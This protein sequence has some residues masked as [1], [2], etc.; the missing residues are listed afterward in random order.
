MAWRKLYPK[1][2][3]GIP[4]NEESANR[5]TGDIPD[6]VPVI[7][8]SGEFSNSVFSITTQ[9]LGT[10]IAQLLFPAIRK[11]LIILDDPREIEDII[12]RRNKEFDK[13]PMA[14]DIFSPMFPHA[15]ISQYTTPKLKAQKRLWAD[16]MNTEFLRRA[17]APN[18]HKATLEL[19]E[20]WKLKASTIYKD[21]SFSTLEDFRNAALDAIWVALIGEEPG[22]TRFEI[23]KL[24]RQIAGNG[25]IQNK[26]PAGV[27]L[28]EEVAYIGQ[29]IARNSNTPVPK[30][31][32]KLETYT[33]RYRKFRSTVTREISLAMEK[34]VHRFE[35]L[36]IGKL[37]ADEYD[38]CMMD[39]VLRRQVLE[40]KKE[41]QVLT[42]PTKD[43]NML[44][45]MF[46]MLV[47]GH[48]STANALT[49]FVRFMEAYPAVQ[50]E[51]RV[52][53]N[54]AFPGSEPPS[55]EDILTTDIPYLDATCEEG[56]RLAGV[57][58]GNLR[59]AIVDT[60]ILGCKIPKGAEIFMN[61]H[62]NRTP[63]PVD[64]SKRTVGS[65]ATAAKH[66]NGL[67]GDAGRDI[68]TF[69]PR[70][71]LVKDEKTGE[72][73]L[74]AYALPNIS[75]G[76]GYRGCFGRK[77]A[78]MEFRIVITLLILNLKFLELPGDFKNMR[79]SEKIFR[80][81]DKPYARL[82]EL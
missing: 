70:R 11:P 62:I 81:P 65:R 82:R 77:L 37:E 75:F 60:E 67:Q 36:E 5:V 45:E 22:I 46:V 7:E 64:E 10:P 76:G 63:V 23:I 16:V 55:V 33:P 12:V 80:Q 9:K 19:I 6:L 61:Y 3:L 71:W 42:D 24:Q 25:D 39:L 79:A 1:P 26:P 14:I 15:S 72:E 40:A 66:G 2:Y 73:V 59:Q 58:K 56:F 53:L 47:G 30:W 51:L 69:E 31:A 50:T 20:L 17:A 29:T 27:F 68:E 28:K 78:F 4:Y 32:Q 38:T 34:A 48:D 57:A 41:K 54:A 35:R 21:Q 8:A 18:I 44:D 43:Q 49:W 74:N 13:A 52:A